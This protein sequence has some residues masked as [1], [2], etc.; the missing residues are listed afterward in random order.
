MCCWKP[1]RCFLLSNLNSF[2][3]QHVV[4]CYRNRR[5][6]IVLPY[7][8][9]IGWDLFREIH[10]YFDLWMF[11]SP[12]GPGNTHDGSIWR[13]AWMDLVWIPCGHVTETM[14]GF[15]K[16][17]NKNSQSKKREETDFNLFKHHDFYTD[18][19]LYTRN[20]FFQRGKKRAGGTVEWT[21]RQIRFSSCMKRGP[22]RKTILPFSPIFVW[23]Q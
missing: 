8:I 1:G 12:G 20:R 10:S 16:S 23:D 2:D 3:M 6:H 13:A 22:S 21:A 14:E 11:L 7:M 19:F 17:P 15:T 4:C 18:F 9:T 5:Y